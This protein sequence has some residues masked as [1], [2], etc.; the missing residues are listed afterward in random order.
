MRSLLKSNTRLVRNPRHVIHSHQCLSFV[1]SP[2]S[3][4]DSDVS[5]API[6]CLCGH[7]VAVQCRT[8][9]IGLWRLHAENMGL[10]RCVRWLRASAIISSFFAV[11]PVL[12]VNVA[13][14]QQHV[15]LCTDERSVHSIKAHDY[16][17]LSVDW[18]KY[19]PNILAT[20]SIDKSIRMWVRCHRCEPIHM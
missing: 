5:R 14:H 8:V 17:I 4:L 2:D 18:N 19:N 7:L 9:C 6:L 10:P 3:A 16:E 13:T 15:S 12:T 1:A 11:C 20:G